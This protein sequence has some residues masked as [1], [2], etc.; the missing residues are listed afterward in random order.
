[1]YYG[2]LSRINSFQLWGHFFRALSIQIKDGQEKN[3]TTIKE[4][5]EKKLDHLAKNKRF[6]PS[7]FGLAHIFFSIKAHQT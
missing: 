4:E 7:L 1:M 5:T 2:I 3:R 6:L